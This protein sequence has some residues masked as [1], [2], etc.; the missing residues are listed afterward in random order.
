[1]TC[2]SVLSFQCPAE[3]KVKKRCFVLCVLIIV[4]LVGVLILGI[5]EGWMY[6]RTGSGFGGTDEPIF[7][8]RAS[9]PVFNTTDST[10]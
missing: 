7:T 5:I 1:M 2:A 10:L 3:K 8:V 9:P 6:T 4:T